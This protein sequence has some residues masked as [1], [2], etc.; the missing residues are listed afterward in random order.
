VKSVGYY[1]GCSLSGTAAEYDHSLRAAFGKMGIELQEVPDWV[2][3]G[4]SSAHAVDHQ[5]AFVLAAD[6]LIKARRGGIERVLAPC[7]MCYQRLATAAHEMAA[8]LQLAR[9][10][11]EALGESPDLHPE[12]VRPLSLLDVLAEWSDEDLKTAAVKPLKGLKVACYYGCLLLRPPK[13]TGAADAEAPRT[14]ERIVGAIGAQPVRWSMATECCGASFAISRKSVVLRQ[15]R[16]IYQAAR[17]A[18]ADLIC[19]A[20]PMCHS[21]LDLRQAEFARGE[22]PLPV[23]YLTQLLGLALGL[24]GEALGLAGHFVPVAPALAKVSA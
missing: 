22:E 19:L 13:V 9:R 2:C 12:K 11:A 10:T 8:D 15:C 7:A 17:S 1:P 23:L 16:R 4:A 3:C 5:A 21:N 20:C 6:T 14:M 18:G 24:S